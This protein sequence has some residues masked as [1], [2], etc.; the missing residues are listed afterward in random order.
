MAR[1]H[2]YQAK[3]LLREHGIATPKGDIATTAAEARQIASDLATPVV[4][5]IQAWT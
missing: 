2:E 4:L 5:K 3:A 1:L